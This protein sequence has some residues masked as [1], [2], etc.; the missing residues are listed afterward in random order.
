MG[1]Q[2]FNARAD[3][4]NRF[5]QYALQADQFAG[6]RNITAHLAGS[7]VWTRKNVLFGPPLG[8]SFA[9]INAPGA[10]NAPV[11]REA[12]PVGQTNKRGSALIRGM[13][14][15]YPTQ[16]GFNPDELSID[17]ATGN[18]ISKK[19]VPT[20]Y[21]ATVVNFDAAPAQAVQVQLLWPEGIPIKYG[22]ITFDDPIN[23]T[24]SI[25]SSGMLWLEQVPSGTYE[26]LLNNENGT[27]RCKVV[28]P[29]ETTGVQDMGEV[30]CE[31][32]TGKPLSA[33]PAEP[34]QEE[35]KQEEETT[36]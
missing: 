13:T 34:K 15:F 25:G 30:K 9:I 16:L 24:I 1:D 33:P 32:L 28:V 31:R 6:E 7:M 5:G 3:Y 14:P 29:E 8:G 4:Q 2:N 12:T 23:Q 19:I 36:P 22:S 21:T 18:A 11:L 26:G 20:P 17:V 10:P 27:A 35:P